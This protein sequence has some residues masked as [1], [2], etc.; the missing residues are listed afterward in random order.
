MNKCP[1][2]FANGYH[3]NGCSRKYATNEITKSLSNWHSVTGHF[4]AERFPDSPLCDTS[5]KL[6]F[7]P[8]C[9]SWDQKEKF[10]SDLAEVV[11]KYMI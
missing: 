10:M 4:E 3:E 6:D 7:E 8:F 11:R 2:C 1:L 5:V 9:I